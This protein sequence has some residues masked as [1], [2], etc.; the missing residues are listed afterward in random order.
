MKTLAER[1]TLLERVT[2]P[3]AAPLYRRFYA[4]SSKD[5]SL[6]ISTEE[7][8]RALPLLEKDTL[9]AAPFHSR[10]FGD[11]GEVDHLRGSSGTTG[12]KPLFSP[13]T[14]LRGMEYRLKYH[15]FKGA[16]LAYT[17]PAMPHWHELFQEEHGLTP[18]VVCFD[19]KRARASVRIAADAGVDS[20]SLFAFHMPIVGPLLVEAGVAKN[21]RFIEL[22][23]ETC[24]RS[25]FE[26]I[27]KTFPNAVIIP[28]Y[29][30]SEVEDSPIGM[31]CRAI[32]GEEPLA[33]Y[34]AKESQYHELIDP[35]TGEW[36]EPVP[37][38]EGEL[39][40]TAYPGEPSALPLIRFKTGDMVRVVEETCPEHR[41]WSFTVLGRVAL[42]FMKIPGGI[43]RVDETERV[44]ALL[45]E[46]VTERFELHRY[47]RTTPEGVRIQVVLRVECVEK[48]CNMNTLSERIAQKLRVGP[49]FTYADGV[50]RGLYLP[51]VCEPLTDPAVEGK[52]TRRFFSH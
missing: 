34:H 22:C 25:L 14:P 51:L 31:P 23:G 43:L 38:A 1:R 4:M 16:L 30:A 3:D 52:K 44:L 35:G 15:D 19:P 18:R 12:K 33:L 49:S 29:G 46:H 17:V 32:T 24:S 40:L 21:I 48:T 47:E 28:F 27:Q 6:R 36:V 8:W 41:G 37:G 5:A 39:I 13:R 26:Y 2:S 50:E 42:D 20:L 10:I 7:E 11:P 9:I 45:R